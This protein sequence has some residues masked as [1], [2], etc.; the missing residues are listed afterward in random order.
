MATQQPSPYAAPETRPT[1]PPRMPR[2][3]TAMV[4]SAA[5]RRMRTP[6]ER[7]IGFALLIGSIIGNVLAFNGG[8]LYPITA[9]ALALG[10]GA[11]VLLTFLQWVY[12]PHG[13]GLFARL[14]TLKWQYLGSVAVGTGLSIAGYATVMYAPALRLFATMPRLQFTFAGV[15]GP[16]LA[17]WLLIS[18]VSLVIEVIPENILVD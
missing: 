8:R 1:P 9:L 5:L 11:Q 15:A 6:L 3:E 16:I 14:H 4:D 10:I 18:V 2:K 13:R 17:A 7:L 12:R